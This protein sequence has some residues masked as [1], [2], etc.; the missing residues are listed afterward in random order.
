[1]NW[2]TFFGA[3]E[4]RNLK[5]VIDSQN[6][7]RQD[8]GNFVPRFESAFGQHLGREYVYAVNSG[9]SA[10]LA[11]YAS[12]GLEPGDEVIVPGLSPIFVSFPVIALGCIPIFADV[13]ALTRIVT[14]KTIEERIS[15]RTKAVVVVHINGQPAAMDE[16]MTMARTH[17]LK[18]VED[19]AQ[20]YDSLY[21]GRKV[22]TIG[23]IACFSLQQCKHITAG[24]G[25]MIATDDPEL[26]MRG[27]LYAN[28]GMAWYRYG[29]EPPIALPVKGLKT[30]GH[31]SF[32]LNLRMSELTAAVA[33]AQLG[34]IDS[35]NEFRRR[36]VDRIEERLRDMDEV[37]LAY[38]Y[39]DTIPNWWFY[40]VWG[41]EHVGQAGEIN[42][43]EP[44][45]QRMQQTRH[46]SAGILL[47]DYVQYVPGIC[48][49]AEASTKGAWDFIPHHGFSAH[50]IDAAVDEF[51]KEVE[52]G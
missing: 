29:L 33:L 18:V 11:A 17:G 3:A 1:M 36:N 12:L 38:S 37:R 14:A 43:I 41:P 20:A 28:V 47:P 48:P 51:I 22:G 35:F 9:T 7:C 34:K 25:G 5:E 32:G 24:E 13:D 52:K 16:I 42:Y 15:P 39:P 10:N 23:D 30:R 8:G 49:I 44:E 45:Y 2:N 4:L 40:T 21:K 26:Y 19:C 46:T 50:E 6:A 31:F 27:L